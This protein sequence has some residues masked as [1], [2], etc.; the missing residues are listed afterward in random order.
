VTVEAALYRDFR[1]LLN[2]GHANRMQIQLENGDGTPKRGARGEMCRWWHRNVLMMAPTDTQ[3]PD[4]IFST[5]AQ[6][7]NMLIRSADRGAWPG[8]RWSTRFPPTV[9]DY[10]SPAR[11]F[12]PFLPGHRMTRFRIRRGYGR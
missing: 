10:G 6:F 12:V 1:A 2:I 4:A 9:C 5:T 7:G 3:H 11:T 8:R